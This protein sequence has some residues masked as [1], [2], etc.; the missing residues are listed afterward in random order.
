MKQQ[1]DDNYGITDEIYIYF[2]DLN[3]ENLQYPI[4]NIKNKGLEDLEDLKTLIEYSVNM[5]D[6]Y[7]N[8]ENSL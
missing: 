2:K 6:V 5:Q 4:K 3:K 7:K 8:V 1:N